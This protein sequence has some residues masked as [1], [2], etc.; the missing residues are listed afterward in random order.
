[1]SVCAEEFPDPALG[2]PSLCYITQLP[3]NSVDKA[4]NDTQ[5]SCVALATSEAGLVRPYHGPWN[6]W[7]T[8]R[9]ARGVVGPERIQADA[10]DSLWH[11][12][13]GRAPPWDSRGIG[14]VLTLGL[15]VKKETVPTTKHVESRQKLG[16]PCPLSSKTSSN[17]LYFLKGSPESSP[18]FL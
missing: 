3:E 15:G 16:P 4:S 8:Q 6:L 2:P 13:L 12:C 5:G 11:L 17:L 1:M 10:Q 14:H 9:L 7:A 18:R